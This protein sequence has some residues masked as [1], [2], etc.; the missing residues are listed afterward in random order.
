LIPPREHGR[1]TGR[2][3][4]G[5]RGAWSAGSGACPDPPAGKGTPPSRDAS[6][7]RA[8]GARTGRPR[9]GRTRRRARDLRTGCREPSALVSGRS[10][11]RV[12]T[13]HAGGLVGSRGGAADPVRRRRQVVF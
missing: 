5:D 12:M 4:R 9:R 6:P 8:P 3:R 10:K 7:T 13:L 11:C 1:L 2:S